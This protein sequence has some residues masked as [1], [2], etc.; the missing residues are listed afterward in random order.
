MSILNINNQTLNDARNLGRINDLLGA[1][2]VELSGGTVAL[3]SDPAAIGAVSKLNAQNKRAQAAAT[4]VQN[5]ASYVQSSDS[6]MKSISSVLGRMSELS[7]YATD[8]TKSS[9]DV[10]LYQV[11]FKQLQDQLRETIGGTTA[12][13][14]GTT[15]IDKPLG[16]FNG[17]VVFGP[18]AGISV[19]SGS[20]AGH[21]I[22]I[23]ETNLRK[24][25]MLAMFQQDAAGNYTFSIT[26]PA[27]SQKITDAIGDLATNRSILGG[28]SRRL[29]LAAQ[30]LAVESQNITSAVS[31][32]QDVDVATASTRLSKLNIL[33]ASGTA[34]L[35]QANQS[36]KSVLQLLKS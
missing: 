33:I 17:V 6:F 28:V 2:L 8:S 29:D 22:V 7:Q 34:M 4:N 11:E 32:I 3:T 5:A 35:S 14:G 18:S 12:E 20:N 16:T 26:D 31:G 36:P 25:A 19:A 23:P 9:G 27:A 10:S 13:I 15:D 24:G 21:D 1:S 30:S